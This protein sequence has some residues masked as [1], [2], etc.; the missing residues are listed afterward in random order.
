VRDAII[1]RRRQVYST[2]NLN[3]LS[4]EC[5]LSAVLV[6]QRDSILA[7][8][9]PIGTAD[10]ARRL[11]EKYG[12]ISAISAETLLASRDDMYTR[13][14]VCAA[15]LRQRNRD[16]RRTNETDRVEDSK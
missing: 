15:I 2:L 8:N 11:R 14:A 10:Y 5:D 4:R 7:G 16:R 1:A 6:T 3:D 12:D 9:C 13:R